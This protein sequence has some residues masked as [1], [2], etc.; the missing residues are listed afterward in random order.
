M[1]TQPLQPLTPLYYRDNFLR[2]CE[3]VQSQYGDI[4]NTD[5]LDHLQAFHALSMSA[6]CL[7][8][9]LISRTGP[10]FRSSKLH[11][12]EIGNVAG[13]IHELTNSSLATRWEAFDVENLAAL[14]TKPE[15]GLMF[16]AQLAGVRVTSKASLIEALGLLALDNNTLQQCQREFDPAPVIAPLGTEH[17]ALLQLLFFGNRHQSLTDFVL[18]D[19]GVARFYPYPLSPDHRLFSCRAAVDEYLACAALADTRYEL[20]DSEQTEQLRDVAEALLELEL[21]FESTRSRWDKLCNRLGRDLERL[22]EYDL[23][24]ALY[25]RSQSHPARERTARILEK[26]KEWAATRLLCESILQEPLTEA[27]HDAATK[28]YPRAMRKLNG[29]RVPRLRDSFEEV[30]LTVPAGE[31]CVELLTAAHLET[32]PGERWRSVHYVENSLMNA[33]FGLAFWPVIFADEPGV[34]HHPFQRAPTDMYTGGFAA[35]RQSMIKDHLLHLESEDL[36]T[37]LTSAYAQYHPFQNHW[38]D[39]RTISESLVR[40]ATRAIPTEH[41]LSIWQ[42]ILFDPQENRR[43]FPDLIAFGEQ[44]GDYAMI[45]VKGPGDTLQDNQKR[46]L[47]FFEATA[48]PAQIAWVTWQNA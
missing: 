1:D 17:I 16:E 26:R 24:I 21:Q 5:E 7:Y 37:L 29:E 33:L 32:E 23:A 11:Y 34:F 36:T 48:I 28:I 3:T 46:W 8:I 45:E 15:L 12:P 10:L 4:L 42:R 22:E 6:Q 20:L 44:R 27:E 35:R 14:Y 47:R 25:S 9:R 30:K 13:A 18:E 31:Q 38:I 2:L 39:W 19:L 41:L 40:Q 43:G